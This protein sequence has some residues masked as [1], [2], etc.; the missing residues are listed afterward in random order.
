MC[1]KVLLMLL[2]GCSAGHAADT[3]NL[4]SR[5]LTIPALAV[6]D[7]LYTTVVVT[8][9]GLVSGP[10]G[11]SA[12]GSVDSYDPAS[13]QITVPAVHVG[14]STFYN[15]VATV[16]GLQ[17]IGS[18][19]GADTY[20]GGH[21]SIPSVQ[22]KGGPAYDNVI[23]TVGSIVSRGGGMPA[24]KDLYDPATRQL[25]I[26]SIQLGGTVYTNAVITVGAVVSLGVVRDWA[27]ESGPSVTDSAAANAVY[28]QQGVGAPGN[29][30]GGR[31]AAATFTGANDTLWMF[32][33]NGYD[34]TGNHGVLNDLWSYSPTSGYWTWQTGANLVNGSA[35]Y[36]I[37]G[38]AGAGNTPAGRLDPMGW[39]TPNGEFWL[40]GG[41]GSLSGGGESDFDEVW[42]FNPANRLWTW[43]SGTQGAGYGLVSY[44][45]G[46]QA[47]DPGGRDSGATWTDLDGNLW[48]F[49]GVNAS[50]GNFDDLWKYSPSTGLWTWVGGVNM[51]TASGQQKGIYGTQGVAAPGNMPGPR[52]W[53]T[54]WV[55]QAGNF[56]LF[57][58]LGF[59]AATAGYLNDLWMYSPASGLWTWVSGSEV[60]SEKGV[61]GKLGLPAPG[62]APG[63]RYSP[64]SWIDAT[65][66]LWLFGGDNFQ[67]GY[68]NDLW[69]FSPRTGL[70]TW[71]SGSSAPNASGVNGTKGIPAL[72]NVPGARFAP[73][74]WTDAPGNLWL[75]G[76]YGYDST[77]FPASMNDLWRY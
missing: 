65:G 56:W 43:V 76:G 49:G 13:G 19:A 58:G 41:S 16:A 46:G 47:P 55:D 64:V 27:W 51:L 5:Q 38:Q 1:R 50:Y 61:Y 71:V 7:A 62:N 72:G 70:W 59:A 36:G 60:A 63:G 66:N 73:V 4:A 3:Y 33:G 48:L 67:I 31:N 37:K 2:A 23:V 75:F 44:G 39:K 69:K 45:A 28:G 52:I 21:L 68:F 74:A 57:G 15:V 32:G 20:T 24:L 30:P 9:G 26:A 10:A 22:I 12:I 17:S 54:T 34:P 35:S 11:T 77:G 6:G 53:A 25:T 42:M 8:I 14:A 18:V 40:F 29:L